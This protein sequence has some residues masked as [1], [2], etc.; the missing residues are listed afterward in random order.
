MNSSSL[1]A[2]DR[3]TCAFV[4]L[5]TSFSTRAAYLLLNHQAYW[6]ARSLG[7]NLQQ[8]MSSRAQIEQAKGIVMAT[9]PV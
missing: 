9:K 7:E 4:S 2:E 8:A 3:R 6:D 1:S 5:P